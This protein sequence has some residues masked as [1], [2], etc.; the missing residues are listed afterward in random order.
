MNKKPTKGDWL[1]ERTDHRGDECL[2]WPFGMMPNGYAQLGTVGDGTNTKCLYA[3]RYVCELKHGPAPAGHEA[4]HSCG[5]RG[6][7]NP[8]HI[9]WKTRAANQADRILHGTAKR[10]GRKLTR[11]Q[12]REIRAL[13]GKLTQRQIAAKFG[14]T[15]QSI[16]QV[17]RKPAN[18]AYDYDLW[19]PEQDAELRKCF[20]AGFR[21][22]AIAAKLNRTDGSIYNR[23]SRLGLK[24]RREE[25][26]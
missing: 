20:A 19:Q 16:S 23:A 12:R 15:F 3:H 11:D 18:P 9:F 5:N 8:N 14:V 13:K 4:A 7:L 10:D 21:V 6:C 26:V 1:R 25:S 22:K 24:I 17:H 2:Y